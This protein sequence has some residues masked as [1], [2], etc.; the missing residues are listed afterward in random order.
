MNIR[1]QQEGENMDP[2]ESRFVITPMLSQ[3]EDLRASLLQ[4]NLPPN[5]K[6]RNVKLGEFGKDP[7]LIRGDS[8]FTVNSP[9]KLS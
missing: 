1:D 4:Q 2:K 8:K 5:M 3:K 6:K 7:N 9:I